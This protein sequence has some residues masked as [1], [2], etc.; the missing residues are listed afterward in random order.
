MGLISSIMWSTVIDVFW[1][2]L[3]LT[4][5]NGPLVLLD[6]ISRVNAD[7]FAFERS[8]EKVRFL[9]LFESILLACHHRNSTEYNR[10][11]INKLNKTKPWG[12]RD[13]LPSNLWLIIIRYRF[14][15]YPS[16]YNF[17]GKR[18]LAKR[19]P[20]TTTIIDSVISAL[21]LQ[22]AMWPFKPFT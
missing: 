3:F 8:Q 9:E 13:L 22:V 16:W 15:F 5:F 14:A 17:D 1:T 21:Q 19:W 20:G 18:T 12:N 10:W 11:P 7:R 6:K 4:L 2:I